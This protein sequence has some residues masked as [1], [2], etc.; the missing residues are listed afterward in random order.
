[1]SGEADL[2]ISYA[3]E[4]SAVAGRL[5]AE[6]VRRG[7]AVWFD[8]A[9]I[10]IGED[11]ARV[12]EAGLGR[13]RYGLVVVSPDSLRKAWPRHETASLLAGGERVL[14]VLHRIT[15][16][17]VERVAPALGRLSSVP[18]SAGLEAV[19]DR[20]LSALRRS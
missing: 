20:V 18:T 4:D 9:T 7:V 15:P 11:F 16:A 19:V 17:E 5:H 13:A 3:S 10:E 14:P 12:I 1:M 2:F 8:R 6:L